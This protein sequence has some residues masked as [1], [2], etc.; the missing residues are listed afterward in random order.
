MKEKLLSVAIVLAVLTI[1]SP[2]FAVDINAFTASPDGLWTNAANWTFGIPT[3]PNALDIPWARLQSDNVTVDAHVAETTYRTQVGY[4]NGAAALTI[5]AGGSLTN[6]DQLQV[7]AVSRTSRNGVTSTMT[8]Y[9][10]YIGT[11]NQ[12]INVG[13][14]NNTAEY[15]GGFHN[16]V[17]NVDGGTISNAGGVLNVANYGT[18]SVGETLYTNDAQGTVIIQNGATVAANKMEINSNSG[19]GAGANNDSITINDSTF[20]L[21]GGY[22]LISQLDGQFYATNSTLKLGDTLVSRN[23]SGFAIVNTGAAKDLELA[24]LRINTDGAVISNANLTGL[25][26]LEVGNNSDTTASL[27]LNFAGSVTNESI[28]GNADG[29]SDDNLDQRGGLKVAASARVT[30]VLDF[31]AGEIVMV[32]NALRTNDLLI[33][34]G[35]GSEGTLNLG[36]NATL[37]GTVGDFKLGGGNAKAADLVNSLT[38]LGDQ[39]WTGTDMVVTNSN[40]SFANL[41]DVRVGFMQNSGGTLAISNSSGIVLGDM[42][43]I[44][45]GDGNGS[46]AGLVVEGGTLALNVTNTL[47]V[48]MGLGSAVTAMPTLSGVI[49][50]LD[51]G[52]GVSDAM[53]DAIL[54]GGAEMFGNLTLNT[55]TLRITTNSNLSIYN[56][57]IG[58]DTVGSHAAYTNTA[59]GDQQQ[60][61]MNN[62]YVNDIADSTGELFMSGGTMTITNVATIGRGQRGTGRV[63]V[64]DGAINA[65]GD[66]RLGDQNQ[67][68]RGEM[69]ISG[70]TVSTLADIE[71]GSNLN[72][73]GVVTMT[74]GTLSA[75]NE[76]DVGLA[77]DLG[78]NGSVGFLTANDAT[79]TAGDLKAAPQQH[80]KGYA[81][82]TNNTVTIGD[83]LGSGLGHN[84][85]GEIYVSGGT[86]TAGSGF[87]DNLVIATGTNSY[88]LMDIKAAVQGGAQFIVN[89]VNV[90]TGTNSTGFLTLHNVGLTNDNITVIGNQLGS[91]GTVNLSNT[92]WLMNGAQDLLA[93]QHVNVGNN[94]GTGILNV[95]GGSIFSSEIEGAGGGDLRVGVSTAVGSS[96]GT[97]NI[98]GGSVVNVG[99]VLQIGY[100]NGA[101]N[102]IGVGTLNITNA[103]LNVEHLQVGQT[104][105]LAQGTMNIQEGA[106]VNVGTTLDGNGYF[107]LGNASNTTAVVNMSGGTVNM[108]DT[109]SANLRL[110]I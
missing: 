33:G 90:G 88:G 3:V 70:G 17:L 85:H 84:S 38:I 104:T 44:Q 100:G 26:T 75:G 91:M 55:T 19:I 102:R 103:T 109:S 18:T 16:S 47:R 46:T 82:L 29:D 68:T 21:V 92:V 53:A 63:V 5:L 36:D 57:Y 7:G 48:G 22:E 86:L 30:G 107:S 89:S 108:L 83:V 96:T 42:N 51:I 10:D 25:A 54:S 13:L 67:N 66:I 27:L 97:L 32:A 78:G 71:I 24:E 64:T 87:N 9:G 60:L 65:T 62:L 37:K 99:D 56:F 93:A 15:T 105:A 61:T 98:A 58:D 77:G 76:I 72:G 4:A 6:A 81:Y 50:S 73:T 49:G 8:I 14:A 95:D 1:I 20:N 39:L 80:T 74:G 110:G 34:A 2:V 41:T 43:V 12:A 11:S 45:V 101:A 31:D 23:S 59:A 52:E 79:I 106:T 94:G 35:N 40:G 28:D 69:S